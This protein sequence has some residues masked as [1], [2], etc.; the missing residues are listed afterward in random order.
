MNTHSD[1]IQKN[2][3]QAA[4]KA[5]QQRE[6]NGKAGLKLADNRPKA[7]AQR[8]LQQMMNNEPQVVQDQAI[9]DEPPMQLMRKSG[10][11]RRSKS[12]MAQVRERLIAGA[13]T[14]SL[15]VGGAVGT[16]VG[17]L[18]LANSWN[19]VGWGLGLGLA[20]GALSSYWRGPANIDKRERVFY[21]SDLDD[22]DEWTPEGVARDHMGRAQTGNVKYPLEEESRDWTGDST[23]VNTSSGPFTYHKGRG[24]KGAQQP[25]VRTNMKN[26]N[27]ARVDDDYD[28]VYRALES[29]DPEI[30][31]E[32][33]YNILQMARGED[34]DVSHETSKVKRAMTFLLGMTQ[35]AEEH[36][37]RTPG[38]AG[39]ARS[40]L[41]SIADGIM[42]FRQGFNRTDGLYLASHKEGGTQKMRDVVSGTRLLDDDVAGNMS[43]ED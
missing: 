38:S 13:D 8:K 25:Y 14:T 3:L 20:A 28:S 39:V 37:T 41:R 5:V 33:A 10:R 9:S 43:E 23:I 30:E 16:G 31:E 40:I 24:K 12:T 1:R 42:T 17:A 21:G 22:S 32:R 2:T 36:S 27:N 35:I 18:A 15:L 11:N 34:V 26:F 4:A 6:R 7:V 29:S 19:P